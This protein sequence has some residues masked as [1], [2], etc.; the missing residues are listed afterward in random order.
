[1]VWPPWSRWPALFG[2]WRSARRNPPARKILAVMPF[3][4]LGD[5]P[6]HEYLAEGVTE[7]LITALAR[8][9]PDRLG[10]I[11][12]TSVMP[13]KAQPKSVREIAADLGA[14]YLVQ[15]SVR[16]SGNRLRLTAQLTETEGQTHL[17]AEVYD[18]D[19]SDLLG[20]ET[21]IA[22]A[23]ARKLSVGLLPKSSPGTL[24]GPAAHE[25]Y[26]KG[27]YFWNKRDEPGLRRSI[28]LF[29]EA[30]VREPEFARAHAGLAMAQASLATAADAAPA[31]EARDLAETG[32]RRALDLNPDL[33]EGHAALAVVRCRFDWSWPDCEEQLRR[34]LDLDANYATARH[35]LGEH[36]LQRGRLSEAQAEL[37]RARTLDPLSA[38]I[39]THVGLSH[40]YA[41]R[42]AAALAAFDQAL[43]I[44]PRFLL[45]RRARGL[46]LL[47]ADRVAE[48]LAALRQARDDHPQNAHATADLGY[49]LALSGK[50]A[51][52]RRC[53]ADLKDL[54][55]QRQVSAYDF[56]VVQAGLGDADAAF[57]S[58]EKAYADRATGVRWLKV[59]T[60]FDGLRSDARYA[61]LVRKVGL[62]D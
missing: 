40:M 58:L 28:E 17:W 38:T 10:V 62:P 5:S 3:Q 37:E 19:A 13:Y 36:L 18:R 47:R 44:D 8:R 6:D 45:A 61:A 39:H 59:E 2:S 48:G 1:M 51:E 29:Q 30:I 56:A 50:I 21:E 16:A 27:L 52:S 53:L 33:P 60:I 49:G 55:Q 46:T 35:W 9:D 7:E 15:G 43:E 14:Q 12:R 41:G 26:L 25:A 57:E 42:H 22:E 32:A 34:S 24:P 54:A 11:A 20:V 31:R 23:I 4:N